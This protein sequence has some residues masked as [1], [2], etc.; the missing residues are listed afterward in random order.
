MSVSTVGGQSALAIQQLIEHARAVRRF[1]APTQHRPEIRHLC[2]AR[3]RSRRIGQPE[4]TI[5][6][7][8][9]LWRHHQQRDRPHRYDEYRA[10]QYV[11]SRQPGE[12]GHGAGHP[13][14]ATANIAQQTAH[15]RS[16]EL[17]SLLNTQAGDR[18]LFSG[19]A[20]DQPAVDTLDHILNGNGAQAGLKQL[21]SERNQADLG[22]NGLGRLVIGSPTA[23]SVPWPRFGLTVWLQARGGDLEPDR[24]GCHRSERLARL[25]LGQFLRRQPSDGDSCSC[26]SISPMAPA[27]I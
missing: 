12:I 17:L 13:P 5:G 22:A 18:Y 9:R 15:P 10:Q 6:R 14:A 11:G 25:A 4:L 26:V 23:T 19:R 16:I 27:R 20:T 8:Q 24:R 7:D 3:H 21:I 2:R 1:A